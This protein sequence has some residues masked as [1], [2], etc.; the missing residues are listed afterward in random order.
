MPWHRFA[1]DVGEA[2][3]LYV[4]GQA[5]PVKLGLAYGFV[6]G[7]CTHGCTGC[8]ALPELIKGHQEQTQMGMVV[9][10]VWSCTHLVASC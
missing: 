9:A 8:T 1:S 4:L 2:R 3:Y 5:E 6:W 7:G 10:F